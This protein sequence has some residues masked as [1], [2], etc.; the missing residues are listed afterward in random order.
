V[1]RT[2]QPTTLIDGIGYRT[3]QQ[4]GVSWVEYELEEPWSVTL[5]FTDRDGGLELS[6][7]HVF[8]ARSEDTLRS[9]NP[10]HAPHEKERVRE[11]TRESDLVPPG[12]LTGRVLRRILKVNGATRAALRNVP[13][14][15]H[16]LAGAGFVAADHSEIAAVPRQP[17]EPMVLLL[18]AAFYAQAVREARPLNAF[19]A[20]ELTKR[21]FRRA[22]SSVPNLAVA[23]REAGFLTKTKQGRKSGELT[24]KAR[25]ALTL[26]RERQQPGQS[27]RIGD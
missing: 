23:A 1:S 17:R 2:K 25:K 11:W 26:L 4:P 27:S 24:P 16:Y 5:G 18:V 8:A 12:G 10:L 7:L 6:E 14:P 15:D 21:G 9:A 22:P 19:I 13:H 20:A 3:W